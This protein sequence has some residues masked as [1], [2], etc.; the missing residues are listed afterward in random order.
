M[1]KRRDWAKA[2]FQNQT[3]G[4]VPRLADADM[5]DESKHRD[6]WHS[7]SKKQKAKSIASFR[8]QIAPLA[9]LGSAKRPEQV[10]KQMISPRIRNLLATA[11][12]ARRKRERIIEELERANNA[13]PRGSKSRS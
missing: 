8:D 12:A 2:K 6:W 3:A 4:A 1:T 9:R 5:A 10:A 11:E 13:K 7:K